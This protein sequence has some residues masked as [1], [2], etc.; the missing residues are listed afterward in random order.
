MP[1]PLLRVRRSCSLPLS[2]S[3]PVTTSCPNNACLPPHCTLDTLPRHLQLGLDQVGTIRLINYIRAA[4]AGG[5]DPRAA[6]QAAAAAPA[7]SAPWAA[8]EAYLRPVLAD[9]EL[10][11]HD[12][13]GEGEEA[14]GAAGAAAGAAAGGEAGGAGAGG[15]ELQRLA[16]ENEQLRGM[17][18]ALR[19]VVLADDSVRELVDEAAAGAAAA[20]AAGAGP[21]TSQQPA[22]PAPAVAVTTAPANEEAARIDGS[23]FDS[24]STFDIHRDMLADKVG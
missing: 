14:G 23:Y 1:R 3:T 12:W 22:A 16:A 13:E 11:F 9:D 24:Y 7:E 2:P 10:M 15:P 6:L 5:G 21:S 19:A 4:V 8:D 20:A 17:L 18:E